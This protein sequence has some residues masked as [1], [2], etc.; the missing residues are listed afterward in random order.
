MNYYYPT[1]IYI[2]DIQIFLLNILLFHEWSGQYLYFMNG[3]AT[4]EI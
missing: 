3:E 2:E 1:T 4:N